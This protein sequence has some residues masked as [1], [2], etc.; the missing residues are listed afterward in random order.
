[1]T[2][3]II[4]AGGCFWT[5]EAVFRRI[6]GVSKVL[7]GYAGGNSAVSPSYESVSTGSTGHSEAV[8][9]EYD[10]SQTSLHDILEIFWESHDPTT[11]NRQGPDIG[12]QYRS[13]IYYLDSSELQTIVKSINHHQEKIKDPIVTEVMKIDDNHFFKADGFHQNYYAKNLNGIYSKSIIQ[14]K[15]EKIEKTFGIRKSTLLA[16]N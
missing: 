4:L 7:S 2:K 3:K 6:T 11:L 8:L 12:T 15:I 9:I 5:V 14:P 16:N 13:A 10:N 1:M